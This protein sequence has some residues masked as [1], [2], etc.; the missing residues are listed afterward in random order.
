[1][2]GGTFVI[3]RTLPLD[4][5]TGVITVRY[6]PDY[7]ERARALQRSYG[8]AV[9]HYRKMFA[10]ERAGDLTA[11]LA[12]LNP[13]HWSAIFPAAPYGLAAI[14]GTG[15]LHF[16]V[17]MP[18]DDRG[19]L[20]DYFRKRGLTARSEV[21]SAVDLAGFTALGHVLAIQYLYVLAPPALTDLTLRWFDEF[22]ANYISLGYLW[23]T[24]GTEADPIRS[25]LVANDTPQYTTLADFDE[26]YPEL[27]TDHF[28][29]L[30][31]FQFQFVQRGR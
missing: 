11:S 2:D 18:A 5:L 21:Q 25:E 1:L 26:H 9:M 31:W 6:S 7:A 16:V 14:L 4:S 30:C 20:A 3:S 22:M 13:E 12:I 19:M 8:E 27:M 17:A 24:Q 10:G 15:G 28:E 29:T 23:H